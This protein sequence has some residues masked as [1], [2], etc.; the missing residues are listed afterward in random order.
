MNLDAAE[1]T[2]EA[3]LDPNWHAEYDEHVT[4]TE[5]GTALVD[6]QDCDAAT[7]DA[8]VTNHDAAALSGYHFE[9]TGGER[10]IVPDAPVETAAEPPTVNQGEPAP[11]GFHYLVHNDGPPRL[12]ADQAPESE[13]APATETPAEGEA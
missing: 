3:G 9:V 10:Q 12:V 1:L 8:H 2:R 11:A 13:E 4:F 6:G 7:L 5:D